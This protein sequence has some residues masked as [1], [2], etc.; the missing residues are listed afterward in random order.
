MIMT[1]NLDRIDAIPFAAHLPDTRDPEWEAISGCIVAFAKELEGFEGDVRSALVDRVSKEFSGCQAID[2]AINI[3]DCLNRY[4]IFQAPFRP[5]MQEELL[6]DRLDSNL[7]I[8]GYLQKRD[9]I[10]NPSVAAASFGFCT[11]A[12]RLREQEEDPRNQAP[13]LSLVATAIAYGFIDS[14]KEMLRFF[15]EEIK[16]EI[17]SQTFL[18]EEWGERLPMACAITG[19]DL[20]I[21]KTLIGWGYDP[22]WEEPL[23]GAEQFSWPLYAAL[24]SNN[25]ETVDLLLAN[26]VSCVAAD[27]AGREVN[28]IDYCE[29]K[30]GDQHPVLNSPAFIKLLTVNTL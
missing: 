27:E 12:I 18:E 11:L 3:L 24:V 1:V 14:G 4:Q 16:A 30:L 10:E 28:V 19:G 29:Q 20:E 26:G 22:R 5:I 6:L 15:E 13:I 7:P 9:Y 17:V 2:T 23:N 25:E 21:V 8:N